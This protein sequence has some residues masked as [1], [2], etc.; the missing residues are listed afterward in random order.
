MGKNGLIQRQRATNMAFFNAGLE[1]G[2]QQFIDMLCLVLH[3]PEIMDKDTFAGDRLLKVIKGISNK[4]DEYYLAW[5]RND[6]A[7]YWQAK[8]D[9][10][11]ESAFGVKLQ[12]TFY[13][14]Y[15]HSP[16]FNYATGRWSK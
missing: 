10:N 3:D 2:R 7:D 4:I 9:A 14:R 15:E 12:N 6:E 8:L 13:Q 5:Q 1:S 16:E 11:L